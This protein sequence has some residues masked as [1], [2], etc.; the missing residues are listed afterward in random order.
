[1]I[2]V[3]VCPICGRPP[4]LVLADRH[5]AFCGA[6]DCPTLVWDMHKDLD[7]LL[8]E[9]TSVDLITGKLGMPPGLRPGGQ[10]QNEGHDGQE[11]DHPD[12][13]GQH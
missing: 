11:P 3:P 5:Q 1:V 10:H 2:Q 8:T 9:T 7:T 4:M 12:D 6:D 13:H